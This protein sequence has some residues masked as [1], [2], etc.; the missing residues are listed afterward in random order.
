[1]TSPPPGRRAA[2]L[3]LLGLGLLWGST[4][5]VVK[6]ALDDAS[7]VVFLALRF[8]VGAAALLV[9]LR[10]VPTSPVVWKRGLL[11]GVLLA[12]GYLTQT[13]GL[14][15]TTPARS[16]FFTGL[17][18]LLV[19]FVSWFLDQRRPG[20]AALVG[21]ALAVAGTYFLSGQGGAALGPGELLTLACAVAYALHIA[22]T[23]RLSQGVSAPEL[24]FVQLTVVAGLVLLVLPFSEVR[25]HATWR[26]AGTVV[27]CG[28]V[29]NA[30]AIAVQTWGQARTTAVRAALLFALEPVWA[31]GLSWLL[32]RESLGAPELTGGGLIVLGVVVGEGGGAWLARRTSSAAP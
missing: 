16:A 24:V 20:G 8:P 7:P 2:D 22:L 29:A 21:A 9:W 5:V 13:W 32:G 23:S 4:F 11:L 1:M 28:V 14:E 31:A 3:A 27:I 25:L 10:R 17:S 30:V 18:V 26:F 6:D 15:L 12:L 19:P